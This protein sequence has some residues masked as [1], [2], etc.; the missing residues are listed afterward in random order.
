MAA[1]HR[2]R[3]G[4]LL[5]SLAFVLLF[6]YAIARPSTESLFLEQ[7]GAHALPWAQDARQGARR[8]AH[9]RVVKGGAS[10]VILGLG[11]VGADFAVVLATLGTIGAWLAIT[12]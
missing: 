9:L 8:H 12:L 6:G 7:H 10:L 11:A 2:L 3:S 5:C 1:V 4:V